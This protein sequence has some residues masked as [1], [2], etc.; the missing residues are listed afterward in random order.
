MHQVH[1]ASLVSIGVFRRDL[2]GR[3]RQQHGQNSM[4]HSPFAAVHTSILEMDA[5][6]VQTENKKAKHYYIDANVL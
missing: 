2:H 4:E 6:C 3:H 1:F 5:M